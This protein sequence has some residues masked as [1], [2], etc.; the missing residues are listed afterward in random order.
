MKKSLKLFSA[1]VMALAAFMPASAVN[2]LTVFEG[3]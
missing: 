2:V 3:D 1:L